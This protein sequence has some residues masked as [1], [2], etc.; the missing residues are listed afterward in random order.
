MGLE[1]SHDRG[2]R[3]QGNG[4]RRD[5]RGGD[6]RR[7]WTGEQSERKRGGGGGGG[8]G[9]GFGGGGGGGGAAGDRDGAAAGGGGERVRCAGGSEGTGAV[10]G[11]EVR[12]IA[13]RRGERAGQQRVREGTHRR[14]ATPAV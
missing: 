8:G 5:G 11:G 9:G 13:A 14:T 6:A 1:G 3:A 2:W 12:G 7:G 4:K 10:G